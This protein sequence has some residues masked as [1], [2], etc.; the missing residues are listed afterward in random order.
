MLMNLI[1]CQNQSTN[2]VFYVH[3]HAAYKV[4]LLQELV[5]WFNFPT[6]I[7]LKFYVR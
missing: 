6:L 7:C 4:I 1:F 3:L 2:V 5:V